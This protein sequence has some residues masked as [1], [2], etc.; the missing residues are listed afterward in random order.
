MRLLVTG[1]SGLIGR[2]IVDFLALQHSV[3]I[4]DIKAPIRQDLPFHSVDILN[5]DA[6]CKTITGF[7]AVV[8]LAGIPHPLNDPAEKVF[9]VNTIGT[10]NVLE[11]CATNG[12]S[13]FIFMSSESTLGFAFSTKRILPL[14]IP[15]DEQHPIQPQDPYGLSKAVGE[16][17]CAGFT[18]R[19]GMQTICLRA[20]WIWVPEEREIQLYRQLIT[21]YPRW[22][23]NLWAYIHVLDVARA[24]Q[25]ALVMKI[26]Q[27][28][29]VFYIC[30]NENWVGIESRELLEKFYPEVCDIRNGFSDKMS[31][32]NGNKAKQELGFEPKYTVKDLMD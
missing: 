1:G 11:A 30:A 14:Y 7:D 5:L 6:V 25:C 17:L 31:L 18:D 8:H 12:I 32:I 29:Y 23:K 2:Y 15:I 22:S 20:P 26:S 10:Y 19:T 3:E 27:I 13:K 24:I 21:E 16:M 4:L 28:H 9:R